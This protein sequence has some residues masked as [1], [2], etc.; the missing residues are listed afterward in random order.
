MKRVGIAI[1]GILDIIACGSLLVLHYYEFILKWGTSDAFSWGLPIFV[2]AILALI[3][4]IY[5]LKKKTWGWGVAGLI[6]AVA[7][8]V[9]AFIISFAMAF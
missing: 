9:Y 7:G 5:S 6:F 1:F 2:A 3:G 4:G 8:W